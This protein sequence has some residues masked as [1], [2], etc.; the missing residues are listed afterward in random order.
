MNQYNKHFQL[1][2]Q[3]IK[4]ELKSILALRGD[5]ELK[6]D[7][8]FVTKADFLIQEIIQDYFHAN[9]SNCT[10]ISEE[11]KNEIV[12]LSTSE[13]TVMV[14]PIDGTENFTSGL[15]EWGV[16]ISIYNFDK[17]AASLLFM[18]QLN[19]SLSSGDKINYFE[20]RIDGLS[21]SL[22]KEGLLS[23][24]MSQEYRIL[25]CSMYNMFNVIQGSY[26]SF[27]NINGVNAWDLL[28]GINLALEH[29][30][31][32]KIDEKKYNGEFLQPNRKYSVLITR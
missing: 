21:S 2:K 10:F 18:P 20:S 13:I 19:L 30:L 12:D 15:P 3:A 27:T 25:G 5:R 22:S 8:S 9:F 26:R 24:P 32:V 31:K 29:G 7:G 17:H 11:K 28:P 14:D 4:T 16:G 1:I 23:I 6:Y